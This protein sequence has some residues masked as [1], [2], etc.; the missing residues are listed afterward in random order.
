[1]LAETTVRRIGNSQG[2]T[3]PKE[4]CDAVGFPVGKRV[5]LTTDEGG[6]RITSAKGKTIRDRMDEW[7]GVR[8]QSPE[9]DWGQTAGNEL[10]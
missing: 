3:I 9:I 6:V 7:D 4:I 2:I 8:Y 5:V 1:M 10:W